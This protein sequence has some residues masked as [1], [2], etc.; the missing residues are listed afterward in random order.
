MI[1]EVPVETWKTETTCAYCS[2]GCSLVLESCGDMLIKANPDKEGVVNAG[3]ACGKG[4][5]GFDCALLED[6]L[7][8]P[9]VKENGEFREA[10]YYDAIV[11]VGKALQTAAAK[12]GKEAVAVSIS[13]RFTNEEAYAM[14][15]MAE[16]I[17]AK[18]LC[19]NNRQSGLKE[20]FR[21]DASPNTIDE[22]LSTNY[23]LAVGYNAVDN[24]VIQLKMKQAAERG[25]KVALINPADYPQHMNYL[26]NEVYAD[27][28]GFLKQVAKAIVDAGKG[29]DIEG[30]DDF[31]KSL[32]GV[33]ISDEAKAIADDYMAA[34]KAMIVFNQNLVSVD[35]ARLIAD[36]AAVSG[37][38]GSPRDGILQV[39]SKNNS[40]GLI[41]L[42]ITDG[43]EALEGVKALLVFGE[44]A[45]IDRDAL[46]FLAVC[47][48]HMTPLAAKA[49]IVIPGTGF[50]STEGTFTNTE[51]RLQIVEAAI[52]EGVELTNW[53]VAAAIAE[54]FE[55]DFGWEDTDD[56]SAEMDDTVPA[57]KYASL[58]EVL[59]GVVTPEEITLEVTEGDKFADPI[60]CTDSLM[61][62][63]AERLPK[64]ANPTA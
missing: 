7:E 30:F 54:V 53:E 48:T 36:I 18:V 28:L 63:I 23:I 64:A 2:V 43:A 8:E 29:A 47:D 19:M 13:D 24:P 50:A 25:A 56:I 40:Q 42:G 3:L 12:Y 10:E 45:E 52:D 59:G 58:E 4:K 44:E 17:G 33:T 22:L 27:D 26:A 35:A 41:D 34:K 9:L 39:K 51:R 62:V 20:V 61:N 37:H 6:K 5:W 16:V 49:D 32:E 15:T 14:K 60:H 46:E 21:V 38:I 1:K 31:A 11:R 55:E 57:Y